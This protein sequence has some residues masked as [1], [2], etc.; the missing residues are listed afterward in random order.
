[1]GRYN[2]YKD[3]P[4]IYPSD[5]TEAQ[6]NNVLP[7]TMKSRAKNSV[8]LPE[9][10][11]LVR[12]VAGRMRDLSHGRAFESIKKNAVLSDFRPAMFKWLAFFL[13]VIAIIIFVILFSHTIT[14]QND[15]IEKYYIDA[16]KVCT[17]Y[18]KSYGT[19]KWETLDKAEYGKGMTRLTGLC[20]ARQMDFDRDGSDELMLCYNDRNVYTLEV[21]GY[22]GKDFIKLYSEEANKTKDVK[23]GSWISFYYKN[24]KYHICKASPDKPENVKIY[25]LRGDKFK[26]TDECL[27]DYKNNIYTVDGEINASDFETIKLSVIKYSKAEQIV[28]IVTDNIDSFNTVSVPAIH[29][30]KSEAELKSEAYYN[31]VESRNEKYGKA[32]VTNK[33]GVEYLDGLAYVGLVD[34]NNDNN[35]ELVL[36]YR[37]M[38]KES[39]TN[40]YTGEFIIIE[41]PAYC[42]EVYSW[43]GT[44]TSKI[45]S[46]DSI[47]NYLNDSDTNYLMLRNNSDK[48]VDLCFNSYSAVDEWSYNAASR[49]YSLKNG[50]FESV[51]SAREEN[52]YGYKSY[53][54]DGKYSYRSEFSAAAFQV[55]K[56]L[57]DNQSYDKNKYT[58]IYFSGDEKSGYKQTVEDTVKTIQSLNRNYVPE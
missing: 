1:M 3:Y 6:D 10:D 58:L 52:S 14:S 42:M 2:Y 28:N 24:N 16:G 20:Y 31:I 53:Y 39:A 44:V 56:F 54:L 32:A 19:V 23:D 41:E 35:E 47:S 30:Q 46:R 26:E 33:N 34:F 29:S 17:D 48:T 25:T 18:I 51:F 21:W 40:A 7:N 55:P 43:N 45:Y 22:K 36:V 5:E 57:D 8:K 37:K 4:L 11:K 9:P 50:S 38:I 27:Y 12:A 15:K 49:I 13:F